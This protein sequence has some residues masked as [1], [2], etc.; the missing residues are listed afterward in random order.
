MVDQVP[1]PQDDQEGP[2]RT[3][4]EGGAVTNATKPAPCPRPERREMT[5]WRER[6]ARRA[7]SAWLAPHVLSAEAPPARQQFYQE[8]KEILWI[9][10]G[11]QVIED[12]VDRG[13]ITIA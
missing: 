8:V 5:M 4:R 12:A 11:L 3:D 7:G 9:E 6:R 10:A 2:A 13:E 1:D